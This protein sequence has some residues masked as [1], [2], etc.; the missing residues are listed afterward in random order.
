ML[1]CLLIGGHLL[2]GDGDRFINLNNT[3]SMV[4]QKDPESDV[5]VFTAFSG[6][7]GSSGRIGYTP[8]DFSYVFYSEYTTEKLL[9]E[10]RAQVQKD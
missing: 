10:C 2:L 3:H 9:E 5:M 7:L 1:K 6:S 4:F 8:I